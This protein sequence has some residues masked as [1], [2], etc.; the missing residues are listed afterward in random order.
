MIE[1]CQDLMTEIRQQLAYYRASVYKDET[2]AA[3]D[4]RIDQ[5]RLVAELFGDEGP[6]EAFKDYEAMAKAG[7][8]HYVPGECSLSKRIGTLLASLDSDLSRLSAHHSSGD[9]FSGKEFETAVRKHRSQLLAA[10]RHGSR[11]W[12]FFQML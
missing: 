7:A 3:I 10:C 11:Q 1:L 9:P 12:A 8:M 6:G 5:L 4:T 2:R